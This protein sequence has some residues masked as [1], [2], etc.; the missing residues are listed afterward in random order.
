MACDRGVAVLAITDHDTLAGADALQ[1]AALPIRVIP[2]VELS[3]SDMRGLHL[4]GYGAGE[5]AEPLRR[6]LTELTEA[7]KVRAQEILARLDKLGYPLEDTLLHQ[8]G[9]V[10]RRISHGRWWRGAGWVPRRRPSTAFLR[11]A[12]RLM[13]R[14]NGCIWNK[15]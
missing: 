15:P 3:I 8:Q 14:E 13:C 11:R 6:T 5:R 12:R 1:G 7:R 4:L 10:G 9:T 2:G